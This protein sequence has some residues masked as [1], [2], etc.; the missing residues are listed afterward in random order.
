MEDEAEL[1]I[2]HRWALRDSLDANRHALEP[3]QYKYLRDIIDN[4]VEMR[5][6]LRAP[7]PLVLS[8]FRRPQ[9]D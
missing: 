9:S 6:V 4:A 3:R 2:W 5:V 7:E 1:G 8:I